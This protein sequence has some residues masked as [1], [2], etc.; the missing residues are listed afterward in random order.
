RLSIADEIE[1]CARRSNW[2][3]SAEENSWGNDFPLPAEPARLPG[4][5]STPGGELGCT[6]DIGICRSR[7]RFRSPAEDEGAAAALRNPAVYLRPESHEIIDGGNQRNTNY[8]PDRQVGDPVNRKYVVSVDRPF[9][10]AVVQNYRHHGNDLHHHLEFSQIAG[11]DR[12][13]TGGGNGTQSAHQKFAPDDDYRNPR[14]DQARVELHQHYESCSDQKLIGH[15]IEQNT[16]GRNLPALA[17][18][19]PVNSIGH[20][21][22]NKDRRGQQF[23]GAV[24]AAEM[25][26][27]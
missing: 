8:E 24:F 12:E 26:R 13:A 6:G 5:E 18:Q 9:F 7:R 4:E 11:F 23:F 14:Q 1:S 16:H 22:G 3:R 10:P 25:I 17:R 19:V 15:G 27:G 21:S 20:G 2:S